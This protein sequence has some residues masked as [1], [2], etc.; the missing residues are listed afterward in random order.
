LGDPYEYTSDRFS[1]LYGRS[2][3]W[4]S[5]WAKKYKTYYDSLRNDYSKKTLKGYFHFSGSEYIYLD[6]SPYLTF[7]EVCEFANSRLHY[8]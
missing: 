5:E 7:N 4:L 8:S 2:N 6:Y 3:R 1:I